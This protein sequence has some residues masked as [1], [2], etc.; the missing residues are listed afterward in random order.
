MAVTGKT[1]GKGAGQP[2]LTLAYNKDIELGQVKNT[3]N[4]YIIYTQFF[5]LSS[6]CLKLDHEHGG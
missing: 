6:C 3:F 4:R 1:S 2:K 5:A